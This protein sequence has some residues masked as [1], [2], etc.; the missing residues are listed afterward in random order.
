MSRKKNAAQL[1]FALPAAMLAAVEKTMTPQQR[2]ALTPSDARKIMTALGDAAETI[3][4]SRRE[5]IVTNWNP[6]PEKRATE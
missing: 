5:V 4:L 2:E 3:K 1:T 6:S